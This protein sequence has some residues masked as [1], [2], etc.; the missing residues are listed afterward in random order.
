MERISKYQL[1][2]MIILFQIGS[3]PLFELG[4]KAGQDAWL[5]VIISMLL[6]LLLL[7]LFLAIQSREPEKNWSQ[8]LVQYFG[9]FVGKT[10]L[11]LYSIMFT[12]ESM[13]NIRDFGDLTLLTILPHGPISLIMLVMLTLSIYAIYKGI[14]VFFRL[15]EVI[16]V[17][18][19]T[20]Y[21]KKAVGSSGFHLAK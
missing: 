11:L 17:G 10:V 14:E 6:G 7:F 20:F 3:T 4:I 8:L 21:F 18:V 13:R 16:V 19:L 9:S 5:V 15:A 12:Y 2:A 1:G